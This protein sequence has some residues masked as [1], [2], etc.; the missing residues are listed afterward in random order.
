MCEVR[1]KPDDGK[2]IENLS[3]CI[4]RNTFSLEKL[5]YEEG[6]SSVTYR[7]GK[8]RLRDD[9]WEKQEKLPSIFTLGK[10]S[11]KRVEKRSFPLSLL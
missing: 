3:Q 1:I 9:A 4:I 2:G 11:V 5:K 6:D 7:S 8:R 10:I